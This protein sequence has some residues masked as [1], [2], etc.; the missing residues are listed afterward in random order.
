MTNKN[1]TEFEVQQLRTSGL[2]SENE[3]AYKAGDLLIAEN[4]TTGEK[5]IVGQ[6]SII[7]ETNKR[8]LKG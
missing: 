5:R 6:T 1:L 7:S 2:I 8:V 4:P 3:F